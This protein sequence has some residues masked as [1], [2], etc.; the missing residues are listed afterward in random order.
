MEK[1]FSLHTAE[2]DQMI[3]ITSIIEE[4]IREQGVENGIVIVS[5]LHTT[6]GIT[7]N[8]NADPDVKKDMLMRLD[9]VYPW[10]H[11]KDRH[12]EG[13]TAAHLKTSTVGHAQTLIISNGNLVLGTWQ[14]IYFCEF[15]G[16]RKREF[17]V[18][19]I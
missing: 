11:P 19:I 12:G 16:P 2:R 6:A 7:V 13:N 9:E 17:L 18:K 1:R 8:E 3:D 14:G 4:W 10:E 5:S 15:D